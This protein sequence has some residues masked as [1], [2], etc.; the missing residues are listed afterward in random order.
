MLSVSGVRGIVGGSMTPPLAAEFAAAFG[1]HVKASTG[2][3]APVICVGRDSRESGQMLSSAAIAG[4]A[5]VGCRVIDLGIVATP[6]VGVMI[7]HHHAAG[8]IA[9]TASHNP[10]EWNGVKYLVAA[11]GAGGVA[12]PKRDADAIIKRFRDRAITYA[13]VP[14]MQPIESDDGANAIHVNRVV[15]AVDLQQIRAAGLKV[16]LDSV[17]GGG[18]VS[19]RMLLEEL[20]CEVVHLN[21]EPTGRFAH[22]PEPL[23]ENL[24]ELADRTR[25][26]RAA[27]GLAQDP[28]ADRLAIIDENGT[29]IGEEY[30]LALAALRVLE[31][32]GAGT[33]AA[34][35]STSRMIDD[36]AAR[37]PGSHVIR[38]AVGEA[39]VVEAMRTS[40]AILGGEGNGGV[41][42]PQSLPHPRFT[43]RDG[44][45]A[46]TARLAQ[47]ATQLDCCWVAALRDGQDEVRPDRRRRP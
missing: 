21:G 16:V 9:V 17:N 47:R 1:S 30:T 12:P 35:L 32:D 41:V 10:I 3:A 22:T 34:N 46:R 13:D 37:F 23:R 24:T 29:Y 19:G 44:S 18:C 38:T 6:T 26:E 36:V 25:D 27:C 5:S 20:G 45:R 8:G 11:V 43:R 14:A 7:G 28:D 39:N 33:V 31:R 42:W 2:I 4:I 15:E 40:G